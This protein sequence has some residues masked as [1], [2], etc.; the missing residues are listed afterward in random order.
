MGSIQI[1]KKFQKVLE[2]EIEVVYKDFSDRSVG[3]IE[4]LKKVKER[5]IA[6]TRLKV[7]R[8]KVEELRSN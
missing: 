4:R 6:E 3:N 7:L 2:N 5:K 1:I 8:N